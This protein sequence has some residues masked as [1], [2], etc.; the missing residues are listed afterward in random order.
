MNFSIESHMLG[1]VMLTILLSLLMPMAI[2]IANT[3][4]PICDLVA[5]F[6]AAPTQLS[7]GCTNGLPYSNSQPAQNSTQIQQDQQKKVGSAVSCGS[8]LIGAGLIGLALGNILGAGIGLGIG[9]LL[10][11][12][13]V[14]T[15][16]PGQATTFG[17]QVLRAAS[18]LGLGDFLSAIV[19]I[20]SFV[21][22]FF[23][24]GVD[25]ILWLIA[26]IPSDAFIALI[27][28]GI[29]SYSIVLVSL[30]AMKLARGVGII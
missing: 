1:S 27:S 4:S 10:G 26:L 13:I 19:D 23:R 9:G 12:V 20:M 7:F 21:G 15:V 25:Y 17:G 5:V 29:L 28:L 22:A 11:C 8:S 2:P 16:A 24:F 30:F 14:P 6:P 18:G 3:P